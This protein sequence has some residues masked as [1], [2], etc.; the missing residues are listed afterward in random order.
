M[1]Q[2]SRRR[3]YWFLM[4]IDHLTI[5]NFRGFARR[6]FSFHPEV[7]LIV[8]VNGTGKTSLLDALAVALG[9]WFIGIPGYDTRP[10]RRHEVRLTAIPQGREGLSWES[11]YPCSVSAAGVVGEQVLEWTRTLRTPGGN[12]TY[13]G[14]RELRDLAADADG[15]VRTGGDV[16]LPLVSYYGTGRLWDIPR[17]KYKIKSPKALAKKSS[18]SRLEG[19]RNSVDPRISV[20]GLLRWVTEQ[21]WIEY[22]ERAR[23]PVFAAVRKAIMGCVEGATD[24]FFDARR[25][26]VVVTIER[27]GPQP[28]E[29]L[30][31]GQR[32]MMAMVWDLAQKAVTLNPGLGEEA[33]Q[34][35]PGVVLVDELDLHLHPVWQ[36][37]VIENLRG[38]FPRVQFFASTHSPFLIQSLRSGE[39]LVMLEGAAPAQVG[40]RTLEDIAEGVMGVEL[41]EVSDRYDEMRRTATRYLEMLD[42]AALAP[43]EKQE[44]FQKAL[45]E[46]I[47]PY[48]DNPAYQAILEFERIAKLG[49]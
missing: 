22:Q 25:G 1:A 26:E 44:K 12:T 35:T 17:E 34:K 3:G 13:G 27:Q 7:N 21:S 41:A 9:G 5:E 38:T 29:N 39:E 19:Y 23:T 43:V 31:D 10:I 20:T 49:E 30:S 4:R 8:G 46:S 28:F 42:E 18:R 32:T 40:N 2:W 36:R 15:R 45:A 16:I 37:R 48:A 24:L 14:A 47:A 11:Q 6:E 33:P